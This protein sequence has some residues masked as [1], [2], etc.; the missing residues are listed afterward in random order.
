MDPLLAADKEAIGNKDTY[1]DAYFEAFFTKVKPMLE[2][3]LASAI[4]ATASLMLSAWEQ[5]G[6]PDLRNGERGPFSGS[7]ELKR[8]RLVDEASRACRPA[9]VPPRRRRVDPGDIDI[10]R[11]SPASSTRSPAT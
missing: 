7:S 2:E 1:D 3:R 4:T 9:A 8:S 6:K 5:A 11:V 10:R